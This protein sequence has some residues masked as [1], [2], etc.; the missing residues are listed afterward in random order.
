MRPPKRTPKPPEA[1]PATAAG[2]DAVRDRTETVDQRVVALTRR[3]GRME[4]QLEALVRATLVPEDL[5]PP[6]DRLV[7]GRFGIHS[8]FE[9]D[10]VTLGVQRAVGP[11]TRRFVELGSGPNGGNA[12]VLAAELGWTGLMV[13]AD[14]RNVAEASALNPA[15]VTGV[16]DW[17]TAENVNDLIRDAGFSGPI[18][19]LGIDLDGNDLWIWQAIDVVDP[20]VVVVEFNSSFGPERRVSVPYDPQF[21]RPSERGIERM[22]FGASLQA[23]V[24]L[25][26]DRGYRLVAVE[27]HGANAFFVKQE[28][29]PSLPTRAAADVFRSYVKHRGYMRGGTTVTE[30]TRKGLK[31]VKTAPSSRPRRP[32][33]PNRRVDRDDLF[34]DLS[35]HAPLV[36]VSTRSGRFVVSTE[37]QTV[38]RILFVKQSRG[39][40]AVL[41]RAM[42]LLAAEG[43]AERKI[44]L[45]VG[46][47]VG[48][49]TV[50]ALVEHGFERVV[51]F[52]PEPENQ[53]L[54]NA[55][56]ALNDLLDRVTV[57]RV[58][59]SDAEGTLPMLVHPFNSGGHEIPRADGKPF[60]G[61]L[62]DGAEVE[63]IEVPAV[64]LDADL[65]RLAIA[66]A[67]VALLWLD[68]Q[69]HEPSVLRGARS[70]LEAGVPIVTEFHPDMLDSAGTREVFQSVVAPHYTRALDLRRPKAGTTSLSELLGSV[71][72]AKERGAGTFTDLLLLP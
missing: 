50:A 57:R 66:P 12:G 22:Y 48:T 38:A 55:N 41:T 15:R 26:N 16:A 69:G 70:V 7:A 17:I 21:R 18:D 6:E 13:D 65:E 20:R 23:F 53:R 3:L 46:A 33:D 27:P 42:E 60:E 14:E 39:E 72:A 40:M 43:R 34:Q 8:Q 68:V 36:G 44:L 32:A 61:E 10:G 45:D 47:N 30:L 1:E 58:A 28:L 54:L 4:M 71:D 19:Q 2:V 31:L 29:A 59:V 52:E 35:G 51:S 64:T 67:D 25:A 63:E 11:S 9:E 49:T 56:L 62:D 5:V 24:D 37:D